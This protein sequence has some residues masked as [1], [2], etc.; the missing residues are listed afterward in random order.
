MNLYTQWMQGHL[1]RC[2]AAM[3][4]ISLGLMAVSC[5]R[6]LAGQRETIRKA[7]AATVCVEWHHAD[8]A[9]EP[10]ADAGKPLPPGSGLT[11]AI[12]DRVLVNRLRQL[13]DLKSEQKAEIFKYYADLASASSQAAVDQ[14]G[15]ASGTLVSADGLVVTKIVVKPGSQLTVTLSDR[16]KLPAKLLVNDLRSGL[17]LLKVEANDLPFLVPA[18]DPALIG[19]DVAWTYCLGAKDRAASRAMIAAVG[20]D[21]DGQG[22]DLLQIDAAP[23]VGS[24]G[25]P[26]VN[27]QGL[28]IGVIGFSGN[29]Q[30]IGFAI[31]AAAVQRLV[32]ARKGEELVTI[33]R[34]VLGVAFD[35]ESTV[36]SNTLNDAPAAQAGIVKDDQI[37]AIDDEPV[38]SPAELVR[39]ILARSAGQKVR[40]KIRR[41]G[42]EQVFEIVLGA[43]PVETAAAAD[44]K[45]ENLN[46]IKRARVL[47]RPR[48]EYIEQTIDGKPVKI[49]VLKGV[50]DPNVSVPSIQVERTDLDKR[51]ETIARDMNSL[52]EQMEKLTE[53][54]KRMQKQQ[55]R[56]PAE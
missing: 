20:R 38:E 19:D 14:A 6:A 15:L 5:S 18:R 54:L 55:R 7:L 35:S 8:P 32:D 28:L 53:E 11:D 10:A 12:V 16:R 25:A 31:P 1:R 27:E 30:N 13:Q 51:L 49:P 43:R 2:V 44:A 22:H 23:A 39:K 29:S 24:A 4:A 50:V 3:L 37:L 42:N 47:G 46:E 56:L 17:Q 26:L 52:R 36:V 40:V 34:A 21:V 45:V 48:L 41:S 33:P 9:G